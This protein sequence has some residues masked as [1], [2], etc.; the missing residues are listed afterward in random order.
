MKLK[1]SCDRTTNRRIDAVVVAEKQIRLIVQE[2][3]SRRNGNV[4]EKMQQLVALSVEAVI[5]ERM[6]LPTENAT[7]QLSKLSFKEQNIIEVLEDKKF[8]RYSKLIPF[9]NILSF[10]FLPLLTH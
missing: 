4:N 2:W 7:R 5:P 10:W 3:T 9:Y 8:F 1:S 6:G